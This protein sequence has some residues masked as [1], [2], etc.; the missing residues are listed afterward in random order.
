[1]KHISVLAIAEAHTQWVHFEWNNI[2][3]RKNAEE[4]NKRTAS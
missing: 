2:A 3:F 1:M 4:F